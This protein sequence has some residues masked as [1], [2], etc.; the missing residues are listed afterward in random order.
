VDKES[1]AAD[2]P[3]WHSGFFG[4][5]PPDAGKSTGYSLLTLFFNQD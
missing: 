5:N 3:N 1:H 4:H 2:V